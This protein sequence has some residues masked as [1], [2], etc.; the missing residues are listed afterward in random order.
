MCSN[1]RKAY[2]GRNGHIY[3]DLT[4]FSCGNARSWHP[5][6]FPVCEHLSFCAGAAR[7]GRSPG[8]G[9][10]GHAPVPS[11]PRRGCL[12]AHEERRRRK[13]WHRPQSRRRSFIAWAPRVTLLSL[14][15]GG[16][17]SPKSVPIVPLPCTSLFCSVCFFLGL[18][19][20]IRHNACIF[21]ITHTI[22]TLNYSLLF[23]FFILL[24]FFIYL[25]LTLCQVSFWNHNSCIFLH[26]RIFL[27]V[28]CA[29][30]PNA[31]ECT[32]LIGSHLP[33]VRAWNAHGS[34]IRGNPLTFST[35]IL[36]NRF[37][38]AYLQK[39]GDEWTKCQHTTENKRGIVIQDSSALPFVKSSFPF[40]GNSWLQNLSA[41]YDPVW[42]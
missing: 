30:N 34:S 18:N 42:A 7:L 25:L 28:Q 14:F 11:W 26:I 16:N 38:P 4:H 3:N 33:D 29:P 32:N 37:V 8:S 40:S 19:I 17:Y 36:Y 31:E 2:A 21:C 6:Y 5:R 9:C 24:D 15:S 22:S 35:I 12:C 41:F 39:E 1:W 13:W 10:S 20:V 27:L 23:P